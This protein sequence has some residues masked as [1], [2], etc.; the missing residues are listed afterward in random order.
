MYTA[1]TELTKS[2]KRG[3]II[4]KREEGGGGR[5]GGKQPALN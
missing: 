5:E 1:K 2:S 3:H 4:D